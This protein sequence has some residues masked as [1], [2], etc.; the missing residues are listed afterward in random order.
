MK[1]N[2]DEIED[3]EV[4]EIGEIKGSGKVS[5]NTEEMGMFFEMLSKSIYSNPKGSIIREIVSNCFDAHQEAGIKEPVVI[6]VEVEDAITYL[7]FEDFGVGI[8]P[9]RFQSI[10]LNYLRSTKRDTNEQIGYFGLGSKSPFSYTDMFYIRTRYNSIQYQYIMSKG[11][12]A[13]PDWDLMSEVKTEERN[14]T[15]IK[16][17]LEGGKY[18]DD[19]HEFSK[20][21]TG[22]LRYFDDVFCKALGIENDFTILEYDTFK[23]RNK[24]EQREMH[25]VLGKVTY[26]IDWGVIGREQ[27]NIPVGVKFSIGELI[28][29]PNRESIRYSKELSTLINTKINACLKELES[30]CDT[31]YDDLDT[32]I[33]V[34]KEHVKRIAT[35]VGL[36]I[37]IYQGRYYDEKKDVK[38]YPF[39]IPNP[40]WTKLDYK[41]DIPLNPFFVFKVNGYII[42]GAFYSI[43]DEKK[44]ARKLPKDYENI[45]TQIE[46]G[47][48]KIYRTKD[49]KNVPIK[50]KYIEN[51]VVISKRS[52]VLKSTL[53]EL[54]LN[55]TGKSKFGNQGLKNL[56][57][58]GSDEKIGNYNKITII[59]EYIKQITK[60]I[61]AKSVSYDTLEVP[62][63]FIDAHKKSKTRHIS[64]QETLL[65][66][67]MKDGVSAP[68]EQFNRKRLNEFLVVYG[69]NKNKPYLHAISLLTAGRNNARRITVLAINQT[70]FNLMESDNKYD[71]ETFVVN[72]NRVFREQSTAY[73]IYNKWKSLS[74]SFVHD[75]VPAIKVHTDTLDEFMSK[76]VG[77]HYSI[78]KTLE[79][80]FVQEILQMTKEEGILI[81]EWI[82]LVESLEAVQDELI[83][84]KEMLSNKQLKDDYKR[85]LTKFILS[86]GYPVN[87]DYLYNPTEKEQ[88]W[89]IMAEKIHFRPL[90]EIE[91]IEPEEDNKIILTILKT[92]ECPR[93]NFLK[94]T[95]SRLERISTLTLRV[96]RKQ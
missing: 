12:N 55:K 54:K 23:F 24:T 63:S 41:V 80:T 91:R 48:Y 16:F 95:P 74:L 28:I 73:Y 43:H 3:Y 76:R 57:L 46:T 38:E 51:G 52:R 30:L 77:N 17:I 29:T 61:V 90:I 21:I 19:W 8:S 89:K 44:V 96:K 6:S 70:D 31:T 20:E 79:N 34:K 64:T 14:G 81:Q 59:K 84:F 69:S 93:T 87:P 13:I 78:Y 7:C 40:R 15:Q 56:P 65:A 82:D 42:D 5:I 75:Y 50:N 58:I 27:I 2:K 9:E 94:L 66:C 22:Q 72:R 4:E 62:Q 92:V 25:I 60:E 71:L 49:F 86:K 10:Y 32:L 33:K 88:N 26:P 37:P 53:I 67:N 47:N 36:G 68:K 35:K 83:P 1:L 11:Q 45:Y 39:K 85:S 18:G